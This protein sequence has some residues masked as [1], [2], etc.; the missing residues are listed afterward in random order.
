MK[1]RV[2][3]LSHDE[4]FRPFDRAAT[5]ILAM[6]G[7]D[8]VETGAE[9][10]EL[11]Y[12]DVRS[13]SEKLAAPLSA[14]DQTVQSMP[15]VSPTK[16]HLAH[17]SW[18]F[19]TF[20]LKP[21]L[22]RYRPFREE[23]EVLFNSYYNSVG[24]QF[25]RA[26][27][28]LLSRPGKEE[29]LEYR[30][31]VDEAMHRL[32]KELP[33]KARSLVLLG[34]N[35]EEQHQELLLTDIKHVLYQ[36]PLAPAYSALAVNTSSEVSEESE[37]ISFVG[38]EGGIVEVGHSG[39]GFHFDNETPRHRVVLADFE[40]AS[41]PLNNGDVI[42]FIEAGGYDQPLLW[43]SDGWAH[44]KTHGL[45]RPLYFRRDD[46]RW[47]HFTMHGMK[48]VD[49][50]ETACHLSYFEADAIA[51]FMG[52]RLP[53]EFEWEHAAASTGAGDTSPSFGFESLSPGVPPRRTAGTFTQMLGGV[54]EWTQ[55]AYAPYPGYACPPGAVGEYN[56][57]FMHNQ[58]VLRGGSCFTPSFH[59]R[60]TYRNFFP[61]SARWQMSGARL[62]KGNNTP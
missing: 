4:A 5:I 54:W 49:P 28:G 57:K 51:R 26:K 43:L 45:D 18:F 14:E 27:R 47:S 30:K 53:T 17:T 48:P 22:R 58:F 61:S 40:L 38:L 56:G 32:M 1:R 12:D 33:P 55:S 16:W 36:N 21:F 39:A 19:E 52:A 37:S 25:P 9:T 41:R 44:I 2:A 23:Y 11:T 7:A 29:V 59:A 34:L 15:D 46:G 62:A 31:Y 10:L 35:H 3:N 13:H 24:S 6:R 60:I 20:L 8:R 42:A 50:R